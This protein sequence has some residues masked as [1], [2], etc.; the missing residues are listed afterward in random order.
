M[1]LLQLDDLAGA[2]KRSGELIEVT[3]AAV[4]RVKEILSTHPDKAGHGLRIYVTSGGCAGYSYGMAFDAP[5]EKDL[6]VTIDGLQVLLDPESKP[7]LERA[8]VD[9]VESMMGS[10]FSI[11]NP[12]ATAGCGCGHSFSKEE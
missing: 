5:D 9:Y 6:V 11:T 8:R 4:A 10:G 2:V 1:A 3:P 12:N 7:W